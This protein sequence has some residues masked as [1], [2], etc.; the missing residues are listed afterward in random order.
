MTDDIL[1]LARL[2]GT[3]SNSLL[4]LYDLAN[5]R[6]TRSESQQERQRADKTLRR[7][8]EELRKRKVRF[9]PERG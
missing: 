2:R 8:A 1:T 3:D 9:G 7:I 6:F 5:E 4:R